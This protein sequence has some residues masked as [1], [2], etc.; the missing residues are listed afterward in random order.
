MKI[1]Y[2][3]LLF[4][5]VWIS[6]CDLN[7]KPYGFYSDENFFNT[8]EEAESALLYAYNAYTLIEYTRGILYIGELPTESCNV[9]PDEGMGTNDLDEWV[10]SSGNLTLQYFFK[11]SYIAIN[12]ANSVIDN[13]TESNINA[14]AKEEVLGEAYFLRAFS[15]FGLMR[16]F[17]LVPVQLHAVKNRAQTMPYLAK[18]MN[19]LYELMTADLQKAETYLKVKRRV[20][21]ADR[22][23]AQAL[24]AK[25]NLHVA[26]S[27]ESNVQYYVDMPEAVNYY[28]DLAK[29]YAG[30]VVNQ[31]SEYGH[32]PDLMRIYNVDAPTGKEHIFLLS[33]DK[34]GTN[35]GNF[36]KLGQM[37]LTG[38]ASAYYIARPDGSY[39]YTRGGFGV[40]QTT[41]SF[42]DSYHNDDKRKTWLYGGGS[43]TEANLYSTPGGGAINISYKFSLKYV[44]F[45]PDGVKES[46][47]PFLLRYSDIALVYAEAAGPTTEAY[48]LVNQIRARAGLADLTPGLTLAAFRDAVIQ[49]R[50]WELAFEGNRLYDLRRKARVVITDAKAQAAGVSEAQAAFYPIPQLEQDLNP[51]I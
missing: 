40:F 4:A 25:V 32:D 39:V 3:F 48:S 8:P 27:K 36:S 35:E 19:E 38:Q 6:S 47:K 41:S 43:G 22:V 23:A 11:N 34:S 30:R 13:V 10:I 31:Q 16:V 15:Y 20:G 46:S 29:E 45:N 18:N 9:K 21:R 24:M 49:E 1:K 51:N 33:M 5:L 12:R 14:A 28:Y 50:A 26:S 17:G 2:I 37:F 42:Y 44:D 7:E